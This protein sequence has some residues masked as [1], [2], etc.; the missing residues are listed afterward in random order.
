ME[1]PENLQSDSC[2]FCEEQLSM[3]D[4]SHGC[5][6]RTIEGKVTKKVGRFAERVG[7]FRLFYKLTEYNRGYGTIRKDEV[8]DIIR[9]LRRH[10][11]AIH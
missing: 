1:R 5:F 6:G 3:A 9:E 2:P 10:N 4:Y 7:D 8:R 11:R